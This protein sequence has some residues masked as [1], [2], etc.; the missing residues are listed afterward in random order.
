MKTQDASAAT[1]ADAPKGFIERL[2]EATQHE[3]LICDFRLA[4]GTWR[5]ASHATF[6]FVA[7]YLQ[8]HGEDAVRF[9]SG[10]DDFRARY[11]DGMTLGLD[12]VLRPAYWPRPEKERLMSEG[13]A[14]RSA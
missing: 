13:Y 2:A 5:T 4:D 12:G 10:E 14:L 9:V 8:R 7:T 3:M 6:N 1:A 11:G